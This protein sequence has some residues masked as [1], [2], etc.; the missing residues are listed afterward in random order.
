V[1]EARPAGATPPDLAVEP[2]ALA[3]RVGGARVSL[4]RGPETRVGNNFASYRNFLVQQFR[5][6]D[7]EKKGYLIAK[8]LEDRRQAYLRA[9]LEVADRDGDGKL[10]EKEMLAWV[11]LAA[12]GANRTTTVSFT[13]AGRGLFQ[14]LD[15]DQDGRLSVRELRNAWRR[16]ARLDRHRRG[17]VGRDDIPLQYQIAVARGVGYRPVGLNAPAVRSARGPEWFRK[18]DRNGDG[19]VSPREFLGSRADFRKIDADDD[20]LI[21]ALEAERYDAAVRARPKDK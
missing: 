9:L 12:E 15:A 3:V 19:D 4:V 6:L 2:A 16:L 20:G 17:R 7:R 1:I 10:T 14:V 8:Q 18:M 5:E 13:E 21:S 11:D